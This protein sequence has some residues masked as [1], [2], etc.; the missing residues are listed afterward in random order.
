MLVVVF[1]LARVSSRNFV[2]FKLHSPPDLLPHDYIIILFD[3]CCTYYV[4]LKMP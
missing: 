3:R 2:D 1:F 4:I